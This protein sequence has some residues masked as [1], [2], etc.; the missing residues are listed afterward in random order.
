SGTVIAGNYI[1]TKA[2][3]IDA[4]GNA[5][6]GIYLVNGP[7]NTRI[8]TDGNGIADAVERNVISG[9]GWDDIGIWGART[10]HT[11]CAG[12]YLRVNIAGVGVNSGARG[13]AGGDQASNTTIGGSSS[14]DPI[15]GRLSGLG[16]VISGNPAAG[17]Y[18]DH[19]AGAL[20][21]GNFIGSDPTGTAA[22]PN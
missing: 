9:N 14:V 17:V 7:V 15:T 19:V 2:N 8:G 5:S 3:G 10:H 11:L 22:V 12:K 13:V 6:D 16:N 1:G 4:L 18:L 21:Q 20:V